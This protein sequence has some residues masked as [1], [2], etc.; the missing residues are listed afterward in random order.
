[1]DGGQALK[2][3]RSTAGFAILATL[4]ALACGVPLARSTERTPV[5]FFVVGDSHFGA[6]G[7]GPLN[8]SLVE[9]LNRLPGSD[10]PDA[11]GGRVET[12]RGVLF[13]G[14]MTDSSAAEEWQEFEAVYGLTG[15]D[16]L[17]KY[18]L[19]E[20]VGNHDIVG[21]SPVPER[22]RR[23]HGALVYSWDWDDLHVVC[24]DL[25]PDAQNLAWLGKDLE[26]VGAKRPLV[27]FFHYSIEGPYSD[28]WEEEQKSA[29]AQALHGRNVLGIFHGH[30]HRAGQYLWR[31][32]DVFLPGS[33]RPSSH[34]LLV[35][36]VG[37]DSLAVGTRDFDTDT[38]R[39]AFV[40]PIRR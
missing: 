15:W 11:L 5:T 4:L 28:F 16:G 31:G 35:V 13:M 3:G 30:Y 18:P 7:M 9:K 20:A 36:R 32:Y 22:V 38:W 12:P 39:D 8:R 33:P 25:H 27:V 23:R 2:T 26:K 19:F 29:L 17:L 37:A 10:Y 40:K 1:V 34:A 21:D 14:D 6:Q 24:L